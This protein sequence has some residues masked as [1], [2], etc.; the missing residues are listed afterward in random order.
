[1][2]LLAALPRLATMEIGALDASVDLRYPGFDQGTQ[3]GVQPK[4]FLFFGNRPEP[5]DEL[6]LDGKV[7][8]ARHDEIMLSG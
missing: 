2:L 6:R 8:N 4:R 7:I 3:F 5:G 1:L